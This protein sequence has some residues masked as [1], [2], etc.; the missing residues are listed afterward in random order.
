MSTELNLSEIKKYLNEF[1]GNILMPEIPEILSKK[2]KI[3][4]DKDNQIVA[5]EI[6][7]IEQV[8]R[9][10]NH[11]LI[12]FNYLK[13]Q[14]YFAAWNELDRVN[15]ALFELRKHLDYVDNKFNLQ[16]IENIIFQLKKLFPYRHFMSRESVTKKKVCSICGSVI[17]IR[18]SCGHTVGEIYNG[19]YCYRIV[20]DMD[21]IGF[22]IVTNPFDQYTVLFPQELEYDYS[23]LE[24]LVQK[25]K[26]PYEKWELN[27]FKHVKEEYK[28]I[29]RND[30]CPC[31]SGKKYKKCCLISGNNEF[32]H[33]R[34]TLNDTPIEYQKPLI[35]AG[36]WKNQK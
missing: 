8:Y 33:Y 1:N 14:K 22:S 11:Y 13:Q 3:E 24:L 35:M 4:V 7:C 10:I 20:K 30:I 27:I 21:F 16:F 29:K 15:I 25:L 5:K 2:K 31:G 23:M 12:L 36:T 28:M 17:S 6:W 26:N 18:T 32:D 19:E 9:I 34:M